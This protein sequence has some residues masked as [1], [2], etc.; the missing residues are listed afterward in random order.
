LAF[1]GG[2]AGGGRRGTA[3]ADIER[4]VVMGL[5]PVSVGV[6]GLAMAL[7]A[8]GM[9]LLGA[10]DGR[11]DDATSGK[12][13]ALVGSLGGALSL[14]F[15][16]IWLVVGAPFGTDDADTVKTQLLYAS[17]SM[18]FALLWT[19]VT[20]AQLWG[21]SLKPTGTMCAFLAMMHVI[22][23]LILPS[24][25]TGLTTHILLTELVFVIY[26]L[27]LL[28]FWALP[29]GKVGP[30]A[31][32]VTSVVGAFATLYLEYFSGGILPTP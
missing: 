31:V 12:T 1:G 27:V 30:R 14:G 6:V 20:A 4:G 10:H 22:E 3:R 8:N 28:G 15:L 16:A 13:V 19:G 11:D 25:G 18:K 7:F 26:V 23:M 2:G 24:L 5:S 32:G 9:Q 21:W 17:L 29:Y